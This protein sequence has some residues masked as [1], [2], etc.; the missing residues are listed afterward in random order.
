MSAQDHESVPHY[1]SLTPEQRDRWEQYLAQRFRKPKSKVSKKDF[2]RAN[3]WQ[4]PS[5]IWTAVDAGLRP[6]EIGR[7]KVSWVDTD[8][9]LLRIPSEDAVKN[10]KR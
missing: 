4:W 7:A 1:N 2:E 8:N 10:D 5:L 9:A 6:Q 3:S